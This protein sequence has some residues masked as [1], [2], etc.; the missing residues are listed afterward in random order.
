MG[1]HCKNLW[2][3]EPTKVFTNVNGNALL[4]IQVS[5]THIY[6]T[7]TWSEWWLQLDY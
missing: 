4:T 3:P 7:D 2:F 6:E 1:R 5:V